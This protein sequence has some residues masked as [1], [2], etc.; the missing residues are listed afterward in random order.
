M[1]RIHFQKYSK[2]RKLSIY[3][4]RFAENTEN[5]TDSFL[6]KYWQAGFKEDILIIKNWI[7]NLED[8]G[9]K[10]HYFRHERRANAGPAH[11]SKLRIYCIRC[12]DNLIILDGGGE[13]RGQTAQDGQETNAAMELMNAVDEA[14]VEKIKDRDIIY[15]FDGM[16]LFGELFVDIS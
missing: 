3:T 12:H 9:A 13:K 1:K 15:S 7:R 14:F 8:R 16:D 6:K 5:E 10:E 11:F 4:V 2:N